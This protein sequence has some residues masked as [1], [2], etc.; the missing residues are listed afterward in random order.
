MS[1]QTRQN[2][3]I[4]PFIRGGFAAVKQG[5]TFLQDAGRA[6]PLAYG[7]VVAQIPATGKWVPVTVVDP[8]IVVASMVCGANGA[9]LAVWQAITDGSFTISV[10]GVEISLTALD[11]SSITALD[12]IVDTINAV[13]LGR[14]IAIY[15]SAA[16]VVSF[17]SPTPGANGSVSVL[18]AGASG[19]D[20][21]G[22]GH[23]NGLAGTVTAGTGN[24]GQ[25]I[26]AGIF[27]GDAITAAAL[28]AGD[29]VNQ[30]ILIGGAVS[31]DTNQVIVE[32]SLTLDSVVVALNKTIGSVLNG[33]GIFAEETID[34]A[35]YEN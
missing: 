24:D 35:S 20:I 12:E 34:V 5:E 10:D 22:A 16:D 19:T 14:C 23:L 13:F 7:T 25:N 33:I 9:V 28:I 17:I 30:P 31:V 18:T 3:D 32:N 11:F 15:D 27:T 1:V 4:T 8:A 6:I 26:P 21:S 29:V 2:N